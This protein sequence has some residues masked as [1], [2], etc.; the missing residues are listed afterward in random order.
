MSDSPRGPF[1]HDVALPER[2]APLWDGLNTH[3]PTVHR[4][5]GKCCLYYTG[6]TGDRQP[7]KGLIGRTATTS[8]SASQWQKSS[9]RTL[10]HMDR[11]S[12]WSWAGRTRATR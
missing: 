3:N 2:G 6:N 9:R 7:T 12:A 11:A 5:G 10:N 1:A 8:A 4:F